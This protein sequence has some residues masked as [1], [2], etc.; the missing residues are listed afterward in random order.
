MGNLLPM[1]MSGGKRSEQY[2]V[3]D[4]LEVEDRV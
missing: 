1:D 2:N 3:P 4:Q